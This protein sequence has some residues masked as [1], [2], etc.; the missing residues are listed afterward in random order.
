VLA[1]D[2]RGAAVVAQ[3]RDISLR[4]MGLY[5]PSRPPSMLLQVRLPGEAPG[6]ELDVPACIVRALPRP[7]G[8][9]EVGVRFLMDGG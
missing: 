9:F 7:G 8:R 5:L 3:G 2:R 1:D 4:G 6:Q